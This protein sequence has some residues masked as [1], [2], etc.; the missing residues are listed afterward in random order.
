MYS[1][2]IGTRFQRYNPLFL[3]KMASELSCTMDL[4][5]YV[6]E[7]FVF[8]LSAHAV[9]RTEPNLSLLT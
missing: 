2:S 8:K 1:A 9:V 4:Y 7:K 5:R 6:K 3:E